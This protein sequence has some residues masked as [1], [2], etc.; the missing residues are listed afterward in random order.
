MFGEN[1][2]DDE[3][4]TTIRSDGFVADDLMKKKDESGLLF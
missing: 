3:E 2:D 1:N 4:M